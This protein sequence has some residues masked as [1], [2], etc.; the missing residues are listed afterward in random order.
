L[1]EGFIAPRT[2]TEKTIAAIW[3][4]VLQ[5][6]QVGIHDDF[7]DLGGHS[8]LATQVISR[9]SDALEVALPLESLFENPTVAA[10]AGQVALK[11]A[12][13]ERTVEIIAQ[14]E[15]LSEPEAKLLLTS[16]NP[17]AGSIG[18]DTDEDE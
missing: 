1:K 9:I 8:L 12:A 5:S 13:S 6:K 17:P 14:V 18:A 7:F 16:L 2:D 15:S 11:K 10:L 4:E 3:G